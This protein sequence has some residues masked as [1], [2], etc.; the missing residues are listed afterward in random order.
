[1]VRDAT[2]ADDSGLRLPNHSG[3]QIPFVNGL[4]FIIASTSD[5]TVVRHS[6]STVCCIRSAD[7][8]LQAVR[9]QRSQTPP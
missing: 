2:G 8:I 4:L 1:M 6:L 9:M 3:R 5:I 7:N